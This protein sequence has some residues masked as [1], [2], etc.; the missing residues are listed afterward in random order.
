MPEPDD[1]ALL[2]Q[3]A[4][5]HSQAAFTALVERHVNLVY[6]TALRRVGNPQAAEEITQAVFV[7]LARKAKSLA[8]GWQRRLVAAVRLGGD[9]G[10][11]ATPLSG[12]LYQTARL[13]AANYQRGEIRRQRREQ[14]AYMQS[15]LNEP[16]TDDAWRQIAPLLDDAMGRLGDKDRNAV[17]LRF[18]ENK[19]LVEVGGALGTS[20]DA[21]K[22]RV[23]RALDK[24][25]KILNRRGVSA[26]TAVIAGAVSTQ[27]VHAAPVGLASAI[28]AGA[29]AKGAAAGSSILTLVEGA[30]KI[31]AWTKVK[32]TA[33]AAAA[34][35]LATGTATL[36][37]S[38][39][40][41]GRT[42]SPPDIQGAWEGV[43]EIPGT[44]GVLQGE[45]ARSRV[46]FHFFKTNGVY[47]AIGEFID[48]APEPFQVTQFSYDYPAVR[49]TRGQD[50][51]QG[52]LKAGATE[53]A[54]T[55][56]RGNLSAPVSLKRTDA[57][58][59][60]PEPLAKIEYAP[61][62]GSNLQGAWNATL[63]GGRVRITI[64]IAEPS[65]GIFRAELDNLTT[66]WLGQPMTVTYNRPEVE[67]RVASGAG[68]FQ[69]ELR[70]GN[71]EMA[72]NWLQGGGQTPIVFK[73]AN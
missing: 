45:K 7:I 3:Y 39:V 63:G 13:T 69:G 2:R 24:L 10:V 52:K 72:G 37:V 48:T 42:V 60:A 73:R 53:I 25:R 17:V 19:S 26:T 4:E 58:D 22:M 1:I 35:I 29:V 59:T 55:L 38:T 23:N 61:R 14:E 30:L 66:S 33:V 31:M 32:T 5:G 64:K 56:R 62:A 43:A 36:I 46:V 70:N 71:T 12:W 57:P 6:A 34:V 21:A 15:L 67:L 20:E 65:P 16:A 9:G 8:G 47:S 50:V 27:A 41:T 11:A 40:H 68:M 49:F 51:Y 44:P 54:A 28:S 18:F